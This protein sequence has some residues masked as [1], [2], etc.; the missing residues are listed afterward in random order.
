MWWRVLLLAL[1]QLWVLPVPPTRAQCANP[2][3]WV[4]F[5]VKNP[6]TSLLNHEFCPTWFTRNFF[7]RA[8]VS[9]S[10]KV[11]RD[12]PLSLVCGFCVGRGSEREPNIT[13]TAGGEATMQ[14]LVLNK[15]KEE[16][17]YHGS[18]KCRITYAISGGIESSGSYECRV[19]F[20][21]RVFKES[22]A[23]QV[24][25]PDL[26]KSEEEMNVKGSRVTLRCPPPPTEGQSALL[27]VWYHP[28]AS[29]P[30]IAAPTTAP[31]VEFRLGGEPLVVAC[32]TYS[33]NSAQRVAIKTFKVR[34]AG[35]TARR[36]TSPRREPEEP[37]GGGQAYGGGYGEAVEED[38]YDEGAPDAQESSAGWTVLMVVIGVF[39]SVCTVVVVI[40]GY[41]QFK[42][43]RSAQ[44]F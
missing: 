44:R 28:L 13:V 17:H 21:E 16:L 12:L 33:L 15:D 35:S 9:T 24:T 5:K 36:V 4:P 34:R 7:T 29:R 3:H 19:G 11:P 37:V 39:L 42:K 8:T 23:Y 26:V 20:G 41:G 40:L 43:M 38:L 1:L 27:H 14:K 6:Y 31:V 22:V 30:T 25:D 2:M 18:H 10:I 32:A